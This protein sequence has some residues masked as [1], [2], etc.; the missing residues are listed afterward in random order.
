[1][2]EKADSL[3]KTVLK[4]K[5]SK[6]A[7]LYFHQWQYEIKLNRERLFLERKIKEAGA[8]FAMGQ[9]PAQK[10]LRK[11]W[12]LYLV[13][14]YAG[15]DVSIVKLNAFGLSEI[16]KVQDEIRKLQERI[17]FSKNTDTFCNK[18]LLS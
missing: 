17:G 1:V 11:Q 6:K 18:G 9:D 8:D 13:K 3:S 7:L 15:C 5:L 12:Y 10:E 16:K 4:D 14:E 2:L